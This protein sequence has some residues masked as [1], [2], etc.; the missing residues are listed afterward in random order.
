MYK[1]ANVYFSLYF[2]NEYAFIIIDKNAYINIKNENPNPRD[3]D[4]KDK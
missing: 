3:D 2:F 1:I 4:I